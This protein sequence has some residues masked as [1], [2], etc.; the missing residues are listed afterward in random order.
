[1]QALSKALDEVKYRIPALVLQ[2]TFTQKTLSWR[3]SPVSVDEQIM[4]LVIRSRVLVDSNIVGGTEVIVPLSNI[5]PEYID[6]YTLVY[7]VPK[8]LIQGR[9]IL[10]VKSIGY[11]GNVGLYVGN[12]SGS[13][14]GQM[15]SQ[16]RF[17]DSVAAA[18]AVGQSY[19]AAPM[20][21]NA[22][23]QLIGDNVVMVKGY[24]QTQINNALR[25]MVTDDVNMNHLQVRSIP[26][27]CKL[28]ELAVK[29]YIYNT[30]IINMGNALLSGGQEL[31]VF[32]TIV[33][34]Y[35]DSEQMYQDFL[36]QT[37]QA[38]AFMNDEQQFG[39]YIK[40]ISGGMH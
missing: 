13:M 18:M 17:K 5:N 16:G 24:N 39:R 21:S 19:S 38:V 23:V 2:Q 40:L 9:S 22:N 34:G 10:S 6:Q 33:D 4:N 15:G 7:H 1:M 37:W 30:L 11:D 26:D 35:A 36:K 28:V 12:T 27:F 3:T 29:S 14:A 32:K 20:T 8:S 25:C 31:G